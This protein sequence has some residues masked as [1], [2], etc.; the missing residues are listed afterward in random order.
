MPQGSILGPLSFLIYI[1]DLPD[2]IVSTAKLFADDTSIISI[3]HNIN[4]SA[5][6]LNTDLANVNEWAYKWKMSFHPDVTKQAQE[7]IF[8]RKLTNTQHPSAYFNGH[9]VS[10]SNVQ[11]HLGMFLDEKLDFNFHL[12]EKICKAYRGIGIIKKLQNILD[13]KSLI[14]MYKS[15]VRPHLDYGDIVFDQ[16]NNNSFIEKI[17]SV[18]YNAALAITGAVRGTSRIKLYKEL[19]LESLS[20]RRWFRRLCAFYKIKTLAMPSYLHSVI[21]NRTHIYNTRLLDTVE[22]FFCRTNIFK[23]SFFPC[24]IVEWNKLDYALRT[25]KSYLVFR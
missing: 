23:Y 6:E 17:E 16:P 21:P 4:R 9:P 2:N 18:Q 25:E 14:T 24:S 7:V 1:N 12:K 15:F 10:I 13:R 20:F 5:R 3:V 8:S 19:G 22:T 11:K